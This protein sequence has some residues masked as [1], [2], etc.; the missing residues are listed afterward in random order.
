MNSL[1]G[2]PPFV[3]HDISILREVVLKEP[4]QPIEGVPEH[5]NSALLKA[6]AKEP[7][8]RFASC[9]AFVEALSGRVRRGV[10]ADA[11]TRV[12]PGA[13][14]EGHALRDRGRADAR[15]SRAWLWLASAAVIVI[16]AAVSIGAVLAHNAKRAETARAATAA[17]QD[18]VQREQDE[19]R[20]QE[21][22]AAEAK[23]IA[24]DN[25]R[26]K[27]ERA[28][29]ATERKA[30]EEQER[31]AKEK[32]TLQPAE[33]K[34]WTSPAAGMEFVWIPVLKIWVGKYE[35]TNSEYRKKEKAHDSKDYQGNS[36]YGERQPVVYVNFD[37]AVAY[38]AWLTE[39]DKAQLGGLRYRVPSEAEWMVFAQCGDGREYPWGNS[40]PPKYGNYGKTSGYDDGYAVSIPVEKS[41]RNDWGLYG[42]GGNVWECCATGASGSSF[43][44]WRGASWYCDFSGN[45]RCACRILVGSARD[46]DDGFRLVVSR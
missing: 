35:V 11:Q 12:H 17:A 41:A 19:R 20:K 43:G 25:Q 3:N 30:Q 13:L 16:F 7:T 33:G 9:K 15:P 23:K 31:I 37:D 6:L 8:Q 1:S 27:A 29:L 18:A 36:L 2:D 39:R 10:I 34:P 46:N 24:G 14:R 42:V 45:L 32:Q 22:L 38:A 28:Q 40:M 4:A 21:A 5:V 44:A 26:L